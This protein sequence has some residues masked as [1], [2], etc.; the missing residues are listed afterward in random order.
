MRRANSI[1]SCGAILLGSL[2]IGWFP[3]ASATTLT[4]GTDT[5]A[6]ESLPDT[7][8]GGG[9]VVEWD[10]SD[11][12]GENHALLYFPIFQSEGGPVDPVVVTGNPNFQAFLRLEVIN[13][14]DGADLHRLT[15][16]FTE[17][18]TWNTL[19]GSGVLPGT[20][21][22]LVADV[23]SADLEVGFHEV[24][25]TASLQAWAATPDSNYGWGFLPIGS[26]GVEFASFEDGNGPVL[27]LGEQEGYVDAGP[28]GTV[29]SYYDAITAGDPNYPTD[30]LLRVWTDPD[31]DDSGWATGAGQF[32][33][34]DGD[35]ETVV[36]ASEITYLFRTSFVAGDEPDELILGLLRDDSAVV[37]LNGVEVLR[38]N[39]PA[40]AIDAS[41]P[42]STTGIENH[43]S[44]FYLDTAEF[45]PNQTNTLAV[46]I[47]NASSSSSDISFDLSLRGVVFVP[48]PNATLQ[49]VFGMTLLALIQSRRVAYAR[50]WPVS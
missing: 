23:L 42:S 18:S 40:G 34:G 44:T 8:Q 29:W 36:V 49:L 48:E 22:E 41:T 27:I 9:L 28:T 20:N 24:E 45:L 30:A 3:T 25:V 26:N 38:D 37:Y 50:V 7:S 32:G 10:G 15:A 6:M 21:A 13:E 47:H 35:E 14:G 31:F 39:L 16:A 5:F 17:T 11:G 2:L 12:G 43:L 4:T 33:Y 1:Y 19:G 46:E